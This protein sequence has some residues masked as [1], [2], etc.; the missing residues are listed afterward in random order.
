MNENVIN[1]IRS[2]K[3]RGMDWI[4]IFPNIFPEDI[5]V[6]YHHIDGC[7]FVVPL[8]K[9]IH[10][11]TLSGIDNEKHL[12][13]ANDWIEFYYGLNPFDFLKEMD[14]YEPQQIDLTSLLKLIKR[15]S[16]KVIHTESW[17]KEHQKNCERCSH[18]WIPRKDVTIVCPHC[19]SPYWNIPRKEKK[20]EEIA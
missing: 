16:K 4:Q 13:W 3:S 14:N 8:P 20:T 11:R 12:E 7:F 15:K 18:T 1:R 9:E 5:P 19:L 17:I 2:S 6:D 10:G